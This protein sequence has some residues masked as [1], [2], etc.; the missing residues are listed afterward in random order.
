ME[1]LEPSHTVDVNKYKT[2]KHYTICEIIQNWKSFDS[3]SESQTYKNLYAFV[4]SSMIHN[5]QKIETKYPLNKWIFFSN[6]N[7]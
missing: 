5:K 7:E 2:D 1:T 3:S 6:I 4:H